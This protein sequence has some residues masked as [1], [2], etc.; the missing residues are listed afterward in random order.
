MNAKSIIAVLLVFGLLL[1]F[2][3]FN[4]GKVDNNRRDEDG[5]QMAQ[6]TNSKLNLDAE[7]ETKT[8]A[9]QS[10]EQ[11]TLEEGQGDDTTQVG[12]R[13]RVHYIGWLAETGEVFDSSLT[14]GL[15]NGFSFAI[16]SGV[17][18]GWSE[19]TVDMKVGE[20]RRLYIP[21]DMGYGEFG[22]GETIPPNA[23]LIFDVELLEIL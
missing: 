6:T 2:F 12:D 13:I 14:N 4:P 7:K 9:L 11:K 23:D 17:I 8:A 20:V 19:G 15:D 1:L 21:S 18:Q 16:G 22:A 5:N 3:I 10:L